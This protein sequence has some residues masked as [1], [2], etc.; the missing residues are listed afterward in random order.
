MRT[1]R[2]SRIVLA[3]V[4]GVTV[5]VAA[6]GGRSVTAST[7]VLSRGTWGGE[8]AGAIVDDTIVHVHIGCTLGNFTPPAVVDDQ[9][10]FSVEG[11]YT[12]RAFPIAVGPPLPAVF[13][14]VVTGSQLT[15]SVAVS[16]TVEKKLVSLGPVT[17]VLGREPRMQTCPICRKPGE[18]TASF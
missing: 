15:L 3:L 18:M 9:G 1:R 4:I 17:V 13:T 5:A 6:C 11:S 10:R 16:D 8:N 7:H 2:S 14:G 12:L